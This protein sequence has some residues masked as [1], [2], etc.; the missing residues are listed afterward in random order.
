MKAKLTAPAATAVRKSS[1]EDDDGRKKAAAP[2]AAAAKKPM[3]AMSEAEMREEV[4]RMMAATTKKPAATSV[5]APLATTTAASATLKAPVKPTASAQPQSTLSPK[6]PPAKA[7]APKSP[8]VPA[9]SAV[10]PGAPPPLKPLEH[11]PVEQPVV[12]KP[13]APSAPQ[14]AKP[15]LATISNPPAR[16]PAPAPA[17]KIVEE[18]QKEEEEEEDDYYDEDFES[19]PDEEAA[20]I[21]EEEEPSESIPALPAAPSLISPNSRPSALDPTPPQT[22]AYMP[23]TPRLAQLVAT[24]QDTITQE[25]TPLSAR[26]APSGWKSPRAT[27]LPAALTKP[28][29]QQPKEAAREVEEVRRVVL[30]SAKQVKAGLTR[31]ED[32]KRLRRAAWVLARVERVEEG[33]ELFSLQPS[34][35]YDVWMRE[36]GRGDKRNAGCQYSDDWRDEEVQTDPTQAEDEDTQAPEDLFVTRMTVKQSEKREDG[37]SDEAAATADEKKRGEIKG[38]NIASRLNW[39][40]AASQLIE[41]LLEENVQLAA[42]TSSEQA[43][44]AG[45]STRYPHLRATTAAL[46]SLVWGQFS[47]TP[48]SIFG[49]RQLRAIH[50]SPSQPDQLILALPPIQPPP[51]DT[52]LYQGLAHCSLLLLYDLSA[53][54]SP[55]F[56][57]RVLY[58]Q[59]ALSCLGV[60]GGRGWCVVAGLEEGSVCVWDLREADGLHRRWQGGVEGVKQSIVLRHASFTSDGPF[61]TSGSDKLTHTAAVTA[62]RF[63]AQ[64]TRVP[65][66]AVDAKTVDVDSAIAAV[67]SSAARSFDIFSLS[68][69]T[70]NDFSFVT[71]DA[72]GLLLSWSAIEARDASLAGSDTDLT[73]AIGSTLKLVRTHAKQHHQQQQAPPTPTTNN[74]PEPNNTTTTTTAHALQLLGTDTDE[75]VIA[76][77]GGRLCREKRYGG[78]SA[79]GRYSLLPAVGGGVEEEGVGGEGEGGGLGG[80]DEVTCIASHPSFDD[81]FVAG[82]RSGL[83]ALY[84][85]HS[86]VAL[87]LFFPSTTSASPITAVHW[88]PSRPATLLTLTAG[89]TLVTHNLLTGESSA[90]QLSGVEGLEVGRGGRAGWMAGVCGGG[91][92]VD[93]FGLKGGEGRDVDEERD[94]VREYLQR[95]R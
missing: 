3:A 15:A 32:V 64:S 33:F 57:S 91:G 48:P 30:P 1:V 60:E 63:V 4:K 6:S 43:L 92:R 59:G 90:V 8:V 18:K 21:D 61:A 37:D 95:L 80:V 12:N 68:S 77:S 47:I 51:T 65:A 79:P 84:S 82:Y 19:V 40:H 52:S 70:G 34:S 46:S 83:V 31:A 38:A 78:R 94:A 66:T 49:P 17:K 75:Y 67:P 10:K 93:V 81:Y 53:P 71:L 27:P 62:I 45:V 73:L 29:T 5:P 76:L 58:C 87:Q 88:H 74:K 11:V 69:S 28:R 26:A 36:V 23:P 13:P 50:L 20:I 41:A 7:T 56:P 86:S 44:A 55:P 2:A 9:V 22:A 85:L 39:V 14:P 24:V 35:Q 72:N 42:S 16:A 25:D 54:T 89:H